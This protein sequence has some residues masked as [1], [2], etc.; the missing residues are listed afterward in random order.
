MLTDPSEISPKDAS[1]ST[2]KLQVAY[3]TL[4]TAYKLLESAS[5]TTDPHTVL[6]MQAIY[7]H[8]TEAI[9]LANEDNKYFQVNPAAIKLLGYTEEEMLQL[10]GPDIITRVIRKHEIE[11]GSPGNQEAQNTQTLAELRRKDGTLIICQYKAVPNIV[12]GTNLSMFFDITEWEYSRQTIER[13][14]TEIK[15]ILDSITDGF[16]CIDRNWIVIYWNREAEQL[17]LNKSEHIIG[18]NLK[19]M[20]SGMLSPKFYAAANTSMEQNTTAIFE[21]FFIPLNRWFEVCTYPSSEGLSI[22][23]KDISERREA[24]NA[25]RAGNERYHLVAKATND[26]VWDWDFENNTVVRPGN[27]LEVF[28]GYNPLPPEAV[29][30]F[31]RSHVHPDDWN[32]MDLARKII[33]DDRRLNYWEGEYRFK[34]ADGEYAYVYDRGYI[35]RD[36]NGTAIRMI[37]ASKDITKQKDQVNEILRI[38]Q[39]LHSLINTTTDFVWSIDKEYRLITANKAFT[40]II[41][42]VSGKSLKEGDNLLQFG[43]SENSHSWLHYYSKVLKGETF[44]FEREFYNPLI[45]GSIFTITTLSP[46]LDNDGNISGVAC[47]MKDITELKKAGN[48]LEELN[49]SLEKRAA[50]LAL[51]NSELERFAYVASHDLQEPLRMITGFLKLLQKKYKGNIDDTADTYIHFSIDGA[52]RMK[53]LITDLLQYSRVGTT[54]LDIV[55]VDMNN[56]VNE[57]L[58]VFQNDIQKLNAVIQVESL[59]A[60][61]AASSAMIQLIQNLVGNALKYRSVQNPVIRITA[62]EAYPYWEFTIE[63]NGIGLDPK[64]SDQI[65]NIFH[66]LHQKDEYSGSGIGLAICRKI[67]ERYHGKIWVESTLGIGSKFIF[68]IPYAQPSQNN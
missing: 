14:K 65:F 8:A 37:G 56:V 52:E 7:N 6:G 47:Y 46:I 59:P 45:T 27:L 41:Y 1:T 32:E 58:H 17:L 63:D 60:V 50:E 3:D 33:F 38:Q 18:K 43:D 55:K 51:S 53:Q 9:L 30:D 26:C 15:N 64:F 62:R 29:D 61:K 57:V 66:R 4:L 24:E 23:F 67:V 16:F 31:W 25:L 11:T 42:A 21:E 28:Y 49:F 40:D 34:K 12:P 39:N 19:E 54:S 68:T 10:S 13:R 48:K 35:L 22:Y 5:N 2:A 44:N 36:Q 20:Y